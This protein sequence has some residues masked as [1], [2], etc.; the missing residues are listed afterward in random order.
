MFSKGRCLI[1]GEV[2]QAHEG[3]LGMAH[4]YIDAAA[5]MGAD[6]IKFQTHYAEHE[7][8]SAEPFRVRF[9]PQDE[10]RYD[11]WKRLEFT[12]EQ[13]RGLAEHCRERGML[14]LSSPFSR[15][16][17]DVLEQ[18][19]VPAWKVASGELPNLPLLDYLCA[20]GKP[21]ILSSGMSGWGELDRAVERVK[22]SGNELCIMQCTTCYP[23]PPE[24]VG[25]NVMQEMRTRYGAFV[26]LSDHSGTMWPAIAGAMLG[27]DVYEGHVTFHRKAFGPDA[28][29]SLTLEDLA[30]TVEGIRFTETMREQPVDKDTSSEAYA[31][32]RNIFNQGLVAARDLPKGC[33]LGPNNIATRKPLRGIPASQYDTVLGRRLRVA[34]AAGT[35]IEEAHLS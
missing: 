14:F 33:V 25:L 17:V 3:S 28:P 2:A 6:A 32:L 1:I 11:Y 31:D 15:Y 8:S 35:P 16:A 9:S 4:A 7:S 29:A 23:C 20:T 27:M 10:T 24:R 34:L 26:G 18:C 19:G 5:K 12:P 13:W 22:L 21:I 30:K